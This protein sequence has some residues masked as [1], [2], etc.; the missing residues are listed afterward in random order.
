MA[1]DA[2][3]VGVEKETLRLWSVIAENDEIAFDLFA[4]VQDFL[5][6]CPAGVYV[7]HVNAVGNVLLGEGVKLLLAFRQCLFFVILWKIR[8]HYAHAKIRDEGDDVECR[9]K[10]L[11]VFDYGRDQ[12]LPAL[13]IGDVDGQQDVFLHFVRSCSWGLSSHGN[14][15]GAML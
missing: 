7:L 8:R 4:Q 14:A 9:V 5:I 10:G 12:F 13:I 11:R 6:G 1:H 3:G 15:L 2:D